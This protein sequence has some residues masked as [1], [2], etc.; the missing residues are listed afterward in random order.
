MPIYEYECQACGQHHEAIQKMS[1]PALKKCPHC[2]KAKLRRLISAPVFRLKGS[3]WYETDFKSDK[4]NKRNLHG[5]E[6]KADAAAKADKADKPE[7][8]SKAEAGDQK[9]GAAP[10]PG[11]SEAK[12]SGTPA[13]GGATKPRKKA[14]SSARAPAR[15]STHRR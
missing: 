7:T 3:G 14:R 13:A 8:P 2:G 6:P 12:A 11:K 4:D 1:E 5:E 9:A 15:K 10:A